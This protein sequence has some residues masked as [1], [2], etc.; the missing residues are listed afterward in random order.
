MTQTYGQSWQD[1]LEAAIKNLG[2]E[3]NNTL[4]EVFQR[5]G[6][7]VD[8]PLLPHA[9]FPA[10]DAKLNFNPS[11]FQIANTS[12]RVLT[13][14]GTTV[15]N[16]PISWVNLQDKSVSDA[17]YFDLTG[18]PVTNTVGKFRRVGFGLDSAGKIK[19]VFSPEETN[20]VD[21]ANPGS[22]S[23]GGGL[24]RGFID[25]VCTNVAGYFKTIGSTASIIENNKI[26]RYPVG[27]GGGTGS[28]NLENVTSNI[29]ADVDDTRDLGTI[30]KYWSNAYINNIFTKDGRL[31]TTAVPEVP[32]AHDIVGPKATYGK[33]R[34]KLTIDSSSNKVDW[35]IGTTELNA[36][37]PDSAKLWPYI[38]IKTALESLMASTDGS[39]RVYTVLMNEKNMKVSADSGDITLLASYANS[40]W[41]KLG[42]GTSDTTAFVYQRAPGLHLYIKDI[43]AHKTNTDDDVDPPYIDDGTWLNK[44]PADHRSRNFSGFVEESK[45]QL[46]KCSIR[47]VE[48]VAGFSG[49]TAGL[50]HYINGTDGE[51]SENQVTNSIVAGLSRSNGQD[52]EVD[53]KDFRIEPDTDIEPNTQD[54]APSWNFDPQ[55]PDAIKGDD[56]G[57]RGFH[58][59]GDNV[60]VMYAEQ[61]V[62][63][64][65]W[66][67]AWSID[68]GKSWKRHN[69][70]R[71]TNFSSSFSEAD[72]FQLNPV[73]LIDGNEIFFAYYNSAGNYLGTVTR[74]GVINPNTG[75]LVL[76]SE[77]SF[78]YTSNYYTT[79]LQAV[80]RNGLIYV[81]C[82]RNDGYVFI[83]KYSNHGATQVENLIIKTGS[84]AISHNYVGTV[85]LPNPSKL[86]VVDHP[87]NPGENRVCFFYNKEYSSDADYVVRMAYTDDQNIVNN[88]ATELVLTQPFDTGWNLLIGST[89]LTPTKI[90]LHIVK[91]H[92]GGD[93]NGATVR[94]A[95]NEYT[96]TSHVKIIDLSL[97][98]PAIENEGSIHWMNRISLFNGYSSENTLGLYFK[99]YNNNIIAASE[100]SIYLTVSREQ[101]TTGYA[102][103]EGGHLAYVPDLS[104]INGSV[105]VVELDE[106]DVFETNEVQLAKLGSDFFIVAKH[107]L[108]K[109]N[110]LIEGKL[111]SRKIALDVSVKPELVTNGTFD[112]DVSGWSNAIWDAGKMWIAAN[113]ST[114]NQVITTEVGKTYVMSFMDSN[115]YSYISIIDNIDSS[116]ISTLYL[117]GAGAG[118]GAG[119]RR[120]MSF[121]ATSTQTKLLFITASSLQG[122]HYDNISVK[123]ADLSWLSMN[124]LVNKINIDDEGFAGR[125]DIFE[126]GNGVF[127]MAEKDKSI[128]GATVSNQ[129]Y[130]QS[131]EVRV[132]DVADQWLK[133]PMEM[134]DSMSTSVGNLSSDAWNS[135]KKGDW[136]VWVHARSATLDTLYYFS[137]DKGKTRHY[138]G[139]FGSGSVVNNSDIRPRVN[140][141]DN[142]KV[143]IVFQKP[144][145]HIQAAIGQFNGDSLVL[146]ESTSVVYTYV[147]GVHSYALK[148]LNGKL[149]W[150]GHRLGGGGDI[151]L[152]VSSDDG[153]TWTERAVTNGTSHIQYGAMLFLVDMGG[154]N[155]RVLI[156][157]S[158]TISTVIRLYYSDNDGVLFNISTAFTAHLG[159]GPILYGGALSEDGTKLALMATRWQGQGLILSVLKNTKAGTLPANFE[160]QNFEIQNTSNY[161]DDYVFRNSALRDNFQEHMARIL[162][163]TNNSLLFVYDLEGGTAECDC[164]LGKIDDI[165]TPVVLQSAVYQAASSWSS[166]ESQILRLSLNEYIHVFKLTSSR[167][168]N[169]TVGMLVSNKIVDLTPE[170]AVLPEYNSAGYT[171]L[172]LGETPWLDIANK[173]AM[174]NFAGMITVN[175]E[176][177]SPMVTFRRH[178]PTSGINSIFTNIYEERQLKE[179]T[180]QWRE[181]PPIASSN[182]A[183]ILEYG[184][185]G[186]DKYRVRAH[187]VNGSSVLIVD[188][189]I[190]DGTTFRRAASISTGTYVAGIFPN[191]HFISYP[192]VLMI[193]KK[194]IISFMA[195]HGSSNVRDIAHG[196]FDSIGNLSLTVVQSALDPVGNTENAQLH[197]DNGKVYSFS[198]IGSAGVYGVTFNVSSDFGATWGPLGLAPFHSAFRYG[199]GFTENDLAGRRLHIF[200]V[201][202]TDAGS[203]Q[204]YWSDDDGATQKGTQSIYSPGTNFNTYA[205]KFFQNKVAI[206]GVVYNDWSN[207]RL[208]VCHDLS[209][210]GNPVFA[211]NG[212]VISNGSL[213]SLDLYDGWT[214]A[215]LNNLFAQHF[216]YT[217]I[218]WETSNSLKILYS[219]FNGGYPE[220][221]ISKIYDLTDVANSIV[222][223]TVFA[224]NFPNTNDY[225]QECHFIYSPSNNKYYVLVK[226]SSSSHANNPT[227]GMWFAKEIIDN[228]PTLSNAIEMGNAENIGFKGPT[229]SIGGFLGLQRPASCGWLAATQKED[230]SSIERIYENDLRGK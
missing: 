213:G 75:D 16:V 79:N 167:V 43:Y 35:K 42:W 202:T 129:A 61:G 223:T 115:S 28:V 230:S 5:L 212:T 200:S 68:G 83:A 47:R 66:Y 2:L 108:D 112:T 177:D 227:Y 71:P 9:S 92:Q 160:L 137:T 50:E 6:K 97:S 186:Y 171:E 221:F 15:Y 25:V 17:Q 125:A 3:E 14:V 60:A 179:L 207:L 111:T 226:I 147:D 86:V 165:D 110:A 208:F 54:D 85:A 162:F 84:L 65:S 56:I 117:F 121:V 34:K 109:T 49:L 199:V 124:D 96:N 145:G 217:R 189:S 64:P 105:T 87:T 1:I 88:W 225:S 174:T 205:F 74:K 139:V 116:F 13:K 176:N 31:G 190:D 154:G 178:N 37:L 198:M 101:A 150:L 219:Q 118:I 201:R 183:D 94:V 192:V 136:I 106:N 184:V 45:S 206:T 134:N 138:G 20:E 132:E 149:Y 46:D 153:D 32:A 161:V 163:S 63:N 104:D 140:I 157:T 107:W 143:C 89:M 193:G 185:D 197:F 169:D 114:N 164:I 80:K 113:N 126:D 57:P 168:G 194:V 10:A 146:T 23:I 51:I 102:W 26:F 30:N 90:A 172:G 159:E 210:A 52:I 187:Q 156:A 216:I 78:H 36:T 135:Y 70:T 133:D 123:E 81:T 120:V 215:N 211:V 100:T 58:K 209:V 53:Y 173:P 151:K 98:T 19:L 122:V 222:R 27:G 8:E 191:P 127:I 7:E 141:D 142:G 228:T 131:Y 204:H 4:L 229:P 203:L 95:T 155:T 181:V 69:T 218:K 29:I 77:I 130:W 72:K 73:V 128:D 103:G 76:E 18:W 158:N 55:I 180:E 59:D 148:K 93:G 39:G 196:E 41:T 144:T 119:N 40:I 48:H 11:Y 67:I 33:W 99:K 224:Q 214:S 166:V 175:P 62:V 182:S 21:L 91:G 195:E 12:W 82:E 38:D 188:I 44:V 220:V 152:S 170:S 22:V 24:D